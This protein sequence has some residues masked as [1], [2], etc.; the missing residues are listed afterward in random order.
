MHSGSPFAKKGGSELDLPKMDIPIGL[1][2]WEVFLPQRYKVQD[3]GGDV[4]SARLLPPGGQAL[5]ELEEGAY[6][7]ATE[8]FENKRK[9]LALGA[10]QIGGY[11]IDGAGDVIPN[12]SVSVVNPSTGATLSV[13]S[14]DSGRW[15]VP[16]M[17]SGPVKI[18]VDAQGFKRAVHN[19][20]H[21]SNR[22]DQYNVALDLGAT[23]ETVEVRAESSAVASPREPS[24]KIP[25]AADQPASANVV[26]LQRRVAGVLPIPVDVPR[27]GASFRFVRP[28]VL[29]EETKVTFSYK[30]K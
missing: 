22:P 3:F 18:T 9:E 14:D 19:G 28:L 13:H 5:A 16:N 21:D 4:I 23:T 25:A 26:N 24:K 27:A 6:V 1:L 2:E 10:G 20:Y 7:A 29:D 8:H 17:Q 30:T 12:A 15:S 11:V